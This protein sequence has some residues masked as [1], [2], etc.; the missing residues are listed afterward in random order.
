MKTIAPL[1]SVIACCVCCAASDVPAP[2]ASTAPAADWSRYEILVKR[3]IFSKDRGRSRSEEKVGEA[4]EKEA[5]PPPKAEASLALIGIVNKDGQLVA[6]VENTLTGA[7]QNVKEG[8]T[9]AR[10]KVSAVTLNKF[11]YDYDGKST[12]ISIGNTL[13][14]GSATRSDSVKA[15]SGT[16]TSHSD[17]GGSDVNSVLER[18]RKKRQEALK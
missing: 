7:I 8:D 16:T 17:S 12:E 14:G 18:M 6:F 10:G 2:A 5:P 9:I 3:N 1:L 4:K 15:A 11:N 13:E